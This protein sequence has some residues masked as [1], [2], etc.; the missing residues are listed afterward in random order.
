MRRPGRI[1]FRLAGW[2]AVIATLAI[3][4]GYPPAVV[5]LVG[6]LESIHQSWLDTP[7]YHSAPARSPTAIRIW[8][9]AEA[10]LMASI[11]AILAGAQL[12][13]AFL[14]GWPGSFAAR[15]GMDRPGSKSET[16]GVE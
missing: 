16:P 8:W 14:G 10:C 5:S 15:A 4:C 9:T 3:F 7:A 11:A 1:T 6:V 13:V 2:T 12:A